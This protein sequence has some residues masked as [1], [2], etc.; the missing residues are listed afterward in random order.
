[1]KFK[2][3]VN[4]D[5]KHF[6]KTTSDEGIKNPFAKEIIWLHVEMLMDSLKKKNIL[7]MLFTS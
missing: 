6:H 3:T 7:A 2:C 4:I 5:Q 1:M